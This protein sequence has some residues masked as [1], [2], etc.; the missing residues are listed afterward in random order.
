MK[1]RL[2]TVIVAGALG[3]LML[4]GCANRIGYVQSEQLSFIKDQFFS[5]VGWTDQGPQ[6]T[7]LLYWLGE[8][9]PLYAIN[10]ENQILFATESG[11]LLRFEENQIIESRSLVP[12]DKA[13]LIRKDKTNLAYWINRKL[14]ATH[15][16]QPWTIERS[17]SR[18]GLDAKFVQVCLKEDETYSNHYSINTDGQLTELRFLI[19]PDYPSVRLELAP[20]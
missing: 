16:C 18:S 5:I 8:T 12:I 1:L 20:E 14:I 3:V 2:E 19:H 13:V 11:A 10:A 15:Q 4:G 17:S 7:W 9:R 6:P